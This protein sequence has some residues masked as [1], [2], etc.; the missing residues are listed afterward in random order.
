[1]LNDR[2]FWIGVVVVLVILVGGGYGLGWFGDS[3]PAT[4]SPQ[5]ETETP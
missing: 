5:E 3:T 4:E 2:R 1:M